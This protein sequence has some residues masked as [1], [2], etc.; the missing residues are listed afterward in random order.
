MEERTEYLENKSRQNNM[1]I[2][3]I[4]EKKEGNDMTAFLKKLFVETL[5]LQGDFE[6]LRAHR[7]Y[8][9][10]KTTRATIVAFL[11]FETK[12]RILHAAWA[13]K[14]V[15]F[16]GVRLFFGHD[17]TNKVNKQR[18]AYK[19]LR[20]QLKTKN[21]KSHILAPAKLKIIFEDGTAQTYQDP[22]AAAKDL[23]KR[24]LISKSQP[25]AA[26]GLDRQT[27]DPNHGQHWEAA[28]KELTSRD[29][30]DLMRKAGRN[31]GLETVE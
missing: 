23:Q 9:E 29:I 7:I 6:I 27:G 1:H 17:F 26:A 8:R 18:A 13:K 10:G 5:D 3:N 31:L 16:E 11:N 15:S 30:T 4:P 24:G 25:V 19:P 20:D 22:Q 14:E 12:M 2:F 21:I 28:G